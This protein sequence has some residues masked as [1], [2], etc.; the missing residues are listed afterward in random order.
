MTLSAVMTLVPEPES[1]EELVE[2]EELK[3][4]CDCKSSQY[5]KVSRAG[6]G[7]D[8]KDNQ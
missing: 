5:V 3:V 1:V 4:R 7:I 2:F 8:E 6:S